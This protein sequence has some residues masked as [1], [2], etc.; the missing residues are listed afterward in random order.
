MALAVAA[1]LAALGRDALCLVHDWRGAPLVAMLYRAS[2][3]PAPP[4]SWRPRRSPTLAALVGASPPRRGH[5]CAGSP[6]LPLGGAQRCRGGRSRRRRDDPPPPHPTDIRNPCL[7]TWLE[8]PSLA[9]RAPPLPISLHP[10]PDRRPSPTQWNVRSSQRRSPTSLECRCRRPREQRGSDWI[11][12]PHG[13]PRSGGRR[14]TLACFVVLASEAWHS[15]AELAKAPMAA[16]VVRE[17]A[18]RLLS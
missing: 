6:P 2:G 16:A 12:G 4:P 18:R 11:P 1:P 14:G 15:V 7:R 9:A 5:R 13:A 10:R 17:A 8:G 3:P